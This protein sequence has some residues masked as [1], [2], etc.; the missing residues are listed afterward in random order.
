MITLLYLSSGLFL[1]WSLGANDAA[2]IF[3]T[4]VGTKMLK[5]RS[6]ALIA[7][8][9]VILGAVFSGSGT[10]ETLGE[11]GSVNKIAGGFIV[12][13]AAGFTVYW[14]TRLRLPVSTSQA[15]VGAIIGWN[16]FSGTLTN[17]NVLTKIISSWI[18]SLILSGVFAFLIYKL[19]ERFNLLVKIHLFR[20]DAYTRFGLVL[21]GAFGAYSLGANNIANVMGVFVSISPFQSLRIG[22]L[23]FSG[24]Q[25]LFL[26]GGIAI[27]IGIYTYSYRVMMTVGKSIFK[28]TPQA[29][30]IVVLAESLVLFM[31]ASKGLHN[32]IVSLG[33]PAVPLVP[34]SSSQLVIG[35]VIGIGLAKKASNIKYRVVGRIVFGWV[36]TPL[37]SLAF[38]LLLLFVWQ[39]VFNQEVCVKKY[40][41]MND[42]VIKR[43]TQS[44]II[45]NYEDFYEV[46]DTELSFRKSLKAAGFR[47]S[48]TIRRIFSVAERNS[49]TFTTRKVEQFEN[50]AVN[51]FTP[52]QM[53]MI[54]RL[55]GKHFIYRWELR[56]N[57]TNLSGKLNVPNL[58]DD[59]LRIIYRH[60]FQIEFDKL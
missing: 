37:I 38:C 55:T 13:L 44:G 50:Q 21:I 59:Q 52:E 23:I 58:T 33:L 46:Y 36:V 3:G 42:V 19:V 56:D 15:I 14:M 49:V 27:A 39:N 45:A 10:S 6:A 24:M 40:F 41:D 28:L 20:L 51:Q 1:G 43:L 35:A 2:N 32:L 4:A 11:L 17:L 47:D 48:E 53:D 34:I 54:K 57:L 26:I 31:F 5:F 25:Q 9:F 16:L 22:P 8:V 30:L 18:M 12:V 7:S 60:F 29:A